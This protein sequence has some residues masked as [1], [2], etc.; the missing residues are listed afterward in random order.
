MRVVTYN[1]RGGGSARRGEQWELIRD[2]L[3]PDIL[4]AQECRPP[5]DHHPRTGEAWAKATRSG[6]GTGVYLAS[7]TLRPIP[8]RGFGGWVVGASS[9]HPGGIN[10]LMA[11]G[12]CKFIKNSVNQNT[13]MSLGTRNGGEVISADSY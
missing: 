6:W 4:L 13:W 3:A 11:D 5:P 9:S 12:S 10:V 1:L 2:Q 8:V 7:G